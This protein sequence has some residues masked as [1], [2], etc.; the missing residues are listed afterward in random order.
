NGQAMNDGA[1]MKLV[2]QQFWNNN[3]DVPAS[4]IEIV[5]LG[6]EVTIEMDE[7]L[8]GCEMYTAYPL[9]IYRNDGVVFGARYHPFEDAVCVGDAGV[10]RSAERTTGKQI[11]RQSAPVSLYFFS[12]C[13]HPVT[14]LDATHQSEILVRRESDLEIRNRFGKRRMEGHRTFP[15]YGHRVD[16]GPHPSDHF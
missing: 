14:L 10:L 1:G 4:P 13:Q 12:L 11:G 6:W 2:E 15:S 9:E 8:Y 16:S 5:D 3:R 7:A